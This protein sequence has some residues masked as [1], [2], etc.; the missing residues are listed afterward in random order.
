MSYA[1]EVL[2]DNPT[3]WTRFADL[4][5]PVNEVGVTPA[6]ADFVV[7]V[8]PAVAGL[9]DKAVRLEVV[10][11]T[12]DT[13]HIIYGEEDT[14]LAPGDFDF[15]SDTP[16][17]GAVAFEFWLKVDAF[18][19]GAQVYLY[20]SRDKLAGGSLF[21]VLQRFNDVFSLRFHLLPTVYTSGTTAPSGYSG[22]IMLP[23]ALGAWHHVVFNMCAAYEQVS[24]A[25]NNLFFDT[26]NQTVFFD[27]HQFGYL[28]GATLVGTIPFGLYSD[29]SAGQVDLTLAEL[30]VYANT[31]L[32][33]QR[34]AAHYA[35][36]MGPGGGGS[37]LALLGVGR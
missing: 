9:V 26:Q 11:D 36:A 14:V 31:R 15:G 1:D 12:S 19:N 23:I 32:S 4:A 10:G 21:L 3:Y 16:P 35:A 24:N 8:T 5:R 2:A 13:E 37:R 29:V 28:A 17:Y 20:S 7:D 27:T 22:D 6:I 25:Y 34:V 33:P 30:A 18:S